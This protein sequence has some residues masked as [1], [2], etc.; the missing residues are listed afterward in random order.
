MPIDDPRPGELHT[1]TLV[2]IADSTPLNLFMVKERAQLPKKITIQS[3]S[4]FRDVDENLED[5]S[6]EE[7]LRDYRPAGKDE[8]EFYKIADTVYVTAAEGK[9]IHYKR[10]NAEGVPEGNSGGIQRDFFGEDYPVFVA[11]KKLEAR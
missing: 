1:K 2:R 10:L 7:F 9:M 3:L 4:A 5:I 8:N 11:S 6:T